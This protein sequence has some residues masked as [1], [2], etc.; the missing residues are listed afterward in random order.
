MKI[1][2]CAF[3]GLFAG[4]PSVQDPLSFHFTDCGDWDRLFCRIES[5]RAG[6]AFNGGK[7][8]RGSSFDGSS[9]GFHFGNR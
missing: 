4:D 1:K 5:L 3:E 8:L 2:N 9:F 7:I 6:Y